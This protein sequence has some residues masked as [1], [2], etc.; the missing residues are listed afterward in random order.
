MGKL[1]IDSNS[2]FALRQSRQLLIIDSDELFSFSRMEFVDICL[3][4]SDGEDFILHSQCYSFCQRIC[5]VDNSEN[6]FT[7][8]YVFK[9][10]FVGQSVE[11]L[12][13]RN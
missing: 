8:S 3:S 4:A 2:D 1:I 10:T 12:V 7:Y 5:N 6:L 13:F 9:K 11:D